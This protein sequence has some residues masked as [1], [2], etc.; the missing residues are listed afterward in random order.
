MEKEYSFESINNFLNQQDF[1]GLKLY[2]E[3]HNLE[4]KN[5]KIVPKT[6]YYAKQAEFWD[7]RQLIKKVGLNSLY[8]SIGNASSA[9]FDARIAQST[10][11]TGR[12][13]VRHMGAKINEIIAGD[14]NYKG[15]AIIY[16]D[17][18]SVYFSAHPVMSKLDEFKDFSW[19]KE[20]VVSLYDQIAD[21]TND[22]FPEFMKSSFNVP[23][24]KS[25]IK[26][27]RELVAT[28]GLFITKKRYAVL[29]Y[30]KEGKRKDVDGR[31]GE[32]KAM[33]LDLKR[34]DT[35]KPVQDF[36][37]TV[38]IAVL[39]DAHKDQVFDMI[40]DFRKEFSSWSSWAKG[41]PK[42]VNNL[43]HYGA[44]KRS[45]E[46]A[47]DVFGGKNNGA[48]KTIPGHVLA[49]INWN[50]LRHIHSDTGSMKIEDGA[51]II[52]CKLRSNPLGLTSVG[53]P[54]D[55]LMLPDWFKNLPF[56][57]ELMSETL[58]TKKVENLLG[59]LGWDLNQARNNE[60]FDQLFSF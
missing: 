58:I 4:I 28:R 59:V 46:S 27:G 7:R 47:G 12:C 56:D 53:Y 57:D 18:D 2:M 10:T 34:S 21:L 1:V 31:P 44:V 20:D 24:E 6:E 33:G 11:L 39:N 55:Q 36:L 13:I 41:S 50:N 49:A 32:I 25:V 60:S 14:Y 5:N 43:T 16:G 40:R 37:N 42:R 48:K 45:Q 3:E 9:W 35:P 29:I 8:G 52:V 51:K 54:V 22:S 15:A 17:T 19:S 38:L 23:S 30:D 26:A